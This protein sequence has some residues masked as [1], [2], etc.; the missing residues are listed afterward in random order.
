MDF[1]HWIEE[2]LDRVLVSNGWRYKFP[3]AQ[4][5]TL[6]ITTSDHLLIFQ[7]RSMVTCDHARRFRFENYWL[8]FP[9]C[10]EIVL[11]NWNSEVIMN[12]EDQ[13][14]VC[15]SA[16]YH[17][18]IDLKEI[19]RKEL[20]ECQN[21]IK[22]Q[23]SSRLGQDRNAIHEAYQKFFQLLHDREVQ[24]KQRAKV[25]WLRERDANTRFFHAM[26][27]DRKR[28]NNVLRF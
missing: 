19:H 13:L 2:K 14:K 26:A 15:G 11:N 9:Q 20:E 21:I 10:K 7:V 27:I 18:G 5:Y 12:L 1:D 3:Y 22:A 8:R 6:D 17:W 24:W 23:H 28:K 16:L 4:A 25:F